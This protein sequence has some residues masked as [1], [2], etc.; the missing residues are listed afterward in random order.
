MWIHCRVYLIFST[1]LAMLNIVTT[2]FQGLLK[3]GRQFLAAR[4]AIGG[5]TLALPWVQSLPSDQLPN[6]IILSK[7]TLPLR[8][9]LQKPTNQPRNRKFRRWAVP[10]GPAWRCSSTSWSFCSE[11]ISAV[12]RN[13]DGR[14][15]S[16]GTHG[17]K[18]ENMGMSTLHAPF[19]VSKWCFP[20]GSWKFA[21]KSGLFSIFWWVTIWKMVMFHGKMSN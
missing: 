6:P 8:L 16:G 18:Y 11:V 14:W 12:E 4:E 15:R 1:Y 17:K 5:C 7:N 13:M 3:S 10:T 21:V 2:R 19:W 20:T 9:Y